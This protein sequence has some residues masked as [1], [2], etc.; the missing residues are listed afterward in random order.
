MRRGQKQVEQAKIK[1]AMQMD[2]KTFQTCLLDTQ[3]ASL[4]IP[5][6]GLSDMV[7]DR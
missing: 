7:F 4:G 2:D 6:R 1:L 3:V 5:R